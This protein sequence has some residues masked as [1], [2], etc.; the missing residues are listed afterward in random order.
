MGEP[1][2]AARLRPPTEA[3]D[4]RRR[5]GH[6]DVIH[7]LDECAICQVSPTV[8]TSGLCRECWR[9]WIGSTIA[10]G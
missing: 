5:V 3:A 8:G 4:E 7:E 1:A 2:P 6:G 9:V 10:G